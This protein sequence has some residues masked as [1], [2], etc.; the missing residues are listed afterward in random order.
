MHFEKK[1][2]CPR[3]P[4]VILCVSLSTKFALKSPRLYG[5]S[6]SPC[7]KF[8][9]DFFQFPNKFSMVLATQLFWCQKDMAIESKITPSSKAVFI[10]FQCTTIDNFSIAQYGF[11]EHQL[12]FLSTV[13]EVEQRYSLFAIDSVISE[14]ALVCICLEVIF[15]SFQS[16]RC[17]LHFLTWS[18]D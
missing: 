8:Y 6:S 17:R 10:R 3:S 16:A 12:Q 4:R 14:D 7:W 18:V 11:F 9:T 1:I 13:F 2:L 15:S 5:S